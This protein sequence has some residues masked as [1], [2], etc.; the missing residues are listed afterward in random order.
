MSISILMG[1]GPFLILRHG[2]LDLCLH[3]QLQTM[4]SVRGVRSLA[5]QAVWHSKQGHAG[6]LRAH[7]IQLLSKLDAFED[8]E[9]K[10]SM[11]RH[12]LTGFL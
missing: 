9:Q 7:D 2:L 1:R 6:I 3:S 4:L 10:G 8:S 5:E 12:I 11:I